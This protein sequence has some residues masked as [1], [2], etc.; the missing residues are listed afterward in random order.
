MSEAYSS[1]V[2]H[3]EIIQRLENWYYK[4]CDG[5]WEHE[6]GVKL[7]TLDNPGWSIDIDMSI[8]PVTFETI[9]IDRSDDDWLRC[10]VEGDVF[11]G[12]C[13]PKNLHEML[14]IFLDWAENLPAVG[15]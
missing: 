8:T 6:F 12:R 2:N 4:Q 11:K 5:D 1:M 15:T 3:L 9:E 13:G 7:I 10:R 14:S